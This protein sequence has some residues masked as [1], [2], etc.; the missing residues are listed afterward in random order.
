MPPRKSKIETGKCIKKSIKFLK[1][2]ANTKKNPNKI[3]DLVEK[4]T[5]EELLSLVEI[6]LNLLRPAFLHPHFYPL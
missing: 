1:N 4:A 2:L 3:L 6:S 5:N